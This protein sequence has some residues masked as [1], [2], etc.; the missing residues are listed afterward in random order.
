MKS[1]SRLYKIITEAKSGNLVDYISTTPEKVMSGVTRTYRRGA[2]KVRDSAPG[3]ESSN[4][5]E[6]LINQVPKKYSSMLRR[7]RRDR[8]RTGRKR[9]PNIASSVNKAL[10]GEK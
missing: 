9:V 2:R 3:S 5:G 4:R 7:A 10:R 8:T 1:Y 6:D